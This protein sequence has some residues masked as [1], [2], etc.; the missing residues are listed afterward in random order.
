MM[1]ITRV[2]AFGALDCHQ[3]SDVNDLVGLGHAAKDRLE[4]RIDDGFATTAAE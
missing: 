1:F 4:S 3:I 2:T